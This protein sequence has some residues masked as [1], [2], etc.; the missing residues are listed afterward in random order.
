[1]RS[2]RRRLQVAYL[3][4][5]FITRFSFLRNEEVFLSVSEVDTTAYGSH[6]GKWSPKPIATGYDKAKFHSNSEFAR[7]LNVMY[8]FLFF[9][10]SS[11][12]IYV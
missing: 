5:I 7:E 10:D 2:D 3:L 9:D 1:M 8:V 12:Q 4:F 11:K 6:D